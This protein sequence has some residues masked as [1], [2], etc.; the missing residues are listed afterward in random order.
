MRFSLR[1]NPGP[2]ATIS[3]IVRW[4]KPVWQKA[5]IAALAPSISASSSA[6]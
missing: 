3:V 1:R 6:S 4:T 2:P 5:S